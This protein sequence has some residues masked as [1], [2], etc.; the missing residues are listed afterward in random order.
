[1]SLLD[2]I[3]QMRIDLEK[4]EDKYLKETPPCCN[5]KC[6]FWRDNS[7]GKCSWS[8]LLEDCKDYMSEFEKET[9]SENF[10]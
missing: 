8:V 3:K 4:L 2:E 7:T 5:K 6:G 9:E 1:M 10:E